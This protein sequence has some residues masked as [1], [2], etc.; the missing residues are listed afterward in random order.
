MVGLYGIVSF[1]VSR[2]TAELGIRIALGA[3]RG[4]VLALVLRDGGL[5]VTIGVVLG[6]GF[7]LLITQPLAVFLVPGLDPADPIS[8]AAT[9]IVL[10]LAG[11]VAIWGPARRATRIEPTI[12]LRVE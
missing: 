4:R 6:I 7:A 5:L 9:L 3:S 8:F 2:R 1:T 11:L 10:M 12:A